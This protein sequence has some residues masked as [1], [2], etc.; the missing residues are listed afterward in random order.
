MGPIP[1]LSLAALAA[2]AT[3]EDDLA[4]RSPELLV[5][6][7]RC[8]ACHESASE[9]VAPE[10]AP[11]LTAVGARKTADGLRRWLHDPHGAKRGTAMPDL[12]SQL[13]PAEREAAV[14]ELVH[15]LAAQGG[16]PVERGGE[17][18]PGELERGRQLFHSVGCV[19]CHAP[20][21]RAEDLESPLWR[22]A[23]DGALAPVAADELGHSA[24]D[25]TV[26]ALASFLLDPLAAR[27]SGRMPSL[28]L[29]PPEARAIAS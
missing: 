3:G 26:E 8:A 14:D 19:A 21:E 27:P 1:V 18:D 29:T 13:G 17:I 4:L 22:S 23:A 11:D 12:S 16:P 7:M 15:Y 5:S 9:R 10:P 6:R 24:F 20:Q 28:A 25:T 2:T